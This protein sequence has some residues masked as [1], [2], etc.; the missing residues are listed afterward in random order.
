M[1]T[2][3]FLILIAVT[4]ALGGAAQFYIKRTFKRYSNV[5]P[6]GGLT[7]AQVAERILQANG[8]AASM[9]ETGASATGT[10]RT[11]VVVRAV[12]GDL[13]DHYDPRKNVVGLS[14]PVYGV[15][16]ISA[17]AVAAHE[18]GHAMQ[19][20]ERYVWGEIRS[21]IVPVVNFGSSLSW[22]L[23]LVGIILNMLQLFWLGIIFYSFAIV[24]QIVTLPVEFN[25]S[26]RALA[27]LQTSGILTSA[28]LPGARRVLNAA[29]L[30]YVAAALVSVLYLLYYIGLGRSSS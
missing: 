28:E 5:R 26:S 24:F 23:I 9:T 2:P 7:G 30:T 20:A 25:A 13:T 8:I 15:S 27:Q 29:A 17:N 22:I 14:K 19:T 18:V 12:D 16:S 1:F 21:A 10:S 6:V 11:S 3:N 4:V